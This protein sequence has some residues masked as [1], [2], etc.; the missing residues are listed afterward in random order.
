MV[1]GVF[2]VM[3]VVVV[4]V[5]VFVVAAVMVANIMEGDCGFI[6]IVLLMMFF[7]AHILPSLDS[8]C[9]SELA[10]FLL[11]SLLQHSSPYAN[12]FPIPFYL[13]TFPSTFHEHLINYPFL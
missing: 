10:R 3:V 4:M 13:F 7:L 9:A 8:S 2:V 5:I 1:V 12:F 11:P 6:C